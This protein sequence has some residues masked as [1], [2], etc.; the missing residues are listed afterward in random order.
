MPNT[1]IQGSIPRIRPLHTRNPPCHK[2]TGVR[3]RKSQIIY[4][5]LNDRYLRYSVNIITSFHFHIFDFPDGAVVPAYIWPW[6][7]RFS[8]F[9][10]HH[11]GASLYCCRRKTPLPDQQKKK[12]KQDESRQKNLKERKQRIDSNLVTA[13]IRPV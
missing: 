4:L 9:L 5:P 2:W 3:M 10:H 11:Q 1:L 13:V 8:I 12:R 7:K 6:L